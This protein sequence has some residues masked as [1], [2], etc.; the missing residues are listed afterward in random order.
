[1]LP[2]ISVRS[3]LKEGSSSA[4]KGTG[5]QVPIARSPSRATRLGRRPDKR[6]GNGMTRAVRSLPRAKG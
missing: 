2:V 6:H 4:A 5:R 3:R 1:M